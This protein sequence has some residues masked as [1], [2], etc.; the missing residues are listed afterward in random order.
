MELNKNTIYHRAGVNFLTEGGIKLFQND[1]IQIGKSIGLGEDGVQCFSVDFSGST[2]SNKVIGNSNWGKYVL[3]A[4]ESSETSLNIIFNTNSSSLKKANIILFSLTYNNTNVYFMI[5][6]SPV[7]S[8]YQCYIKYEVIHEESSIFSSRQLINNNTNDGARFRWN[9]VLTSNGGCM[10]N[11]LANNP[12]TGEMR[13][14]FYSSALSTE[15]SPGS[16]HILKS[17]NLS[18][19]FTKL[20]NL[21]DNEEA[22]CPAIFFVNSKEPEAD[23]STVISP[24]TSFCA[25]CLSPCL[26]MIEIFPKE[27]FAD[28]YN[29]KKGTIPVLTNMTSK[30]S[31]YY[32]PYLYIKETSNE[33]L[34]GVVQLGTKKFI[35]GSYYCLACGEESGS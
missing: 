24:L 14:Q 19:F 17:A 28:S 15:P 3:E 12:A 7:L 32:A 2:D 34:F 22:E 30:I 11:L 18:I 6:I 35:A 31:D 26:P 16:F 23:D 29:N 20:K 5:S 27:F 9:T 21:N 8:P 13:I 33:K 1:C 25:F 10:T 4:L